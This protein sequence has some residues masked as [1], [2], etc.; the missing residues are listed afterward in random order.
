MFPDLY[1]TSAQV[2]PVLML[3]LLWESRFLERVR[4]QSR[5]PR[6]LDPARGVL[7][8]TKRRVR[9]YAGFVATMSVVGT[10]V[11]VLVLAEALPDGPVL[12]AFVCGCVLLTLGT[13]LTR[14]LIDIVLA[15]REPPAA[16]EPP[17]NSARPAD[18]SESGQPDGARGR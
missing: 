15:T 11:A 2:L 9:F 7:F 5:L 1:A 18:L 10:G 3:A 12:R 13:L 4:Q 14:S 17:A 16:T 6:R 8:W